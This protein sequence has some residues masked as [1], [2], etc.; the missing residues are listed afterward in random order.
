MAVTQDDVRHI[1]ELARLAVPEEKLDSLVAE[2]NGILAHM[3]VLSKTDTREV[4]L[5]EFAP[6]D[7]TPTR[8]DGSGPVKLQAPLA[9][10]AVSI[11]DGFIMVP[12]LASHEDTA[13]R[14]P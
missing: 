14:S 8:S 1:A 12:R 10:F 7:S 9:T 4:E 3:E 11:R 13:D 2:L 5:A 6:T